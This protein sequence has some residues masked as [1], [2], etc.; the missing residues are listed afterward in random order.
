MTAPSYYVDAENWKLGS[1]D[2]AEYTLAYYI[3]SPE[4]TIFLK[5]CDMFMVYCG[6]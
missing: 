1:R 5:N 4:I 6:F 3:L 2:C